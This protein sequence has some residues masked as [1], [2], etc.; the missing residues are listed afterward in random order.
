MRKTALECCRAPCIG[1]LRPCV[2]ACVGWLVILAGA[3]SAD[4]KPPHKTAVVNFYGEYL[5]EALRSCQLCHLSDDDISRAPAGTL[6]AEPQPWNA[7]GRALHELAE[8]QLAAGAVR[9]DGILDRI[10]ALAELD[11]DGDGVPNELE[12]VAGTVPGDATSRPDPERLATVQSALERFRLG[13]PQYAWKPFDPVVR[14][15]VSG[16]DA[17]D[18]LIAAEQRRQGLVPRPLAPKAMLLRRVYL[19]LIGLPPTREELAAF[20]ADDSPAAYAS[21]VD[22]LLSSPLYGERWGRHWMDVW[23]YSDWA[24]WGEQVRDSQPHIWRWR[25]WIIESLAADKPYDRMVQEMLAADELAPGDEDALRATGYLVR[26]FKLLSREQW[27]LEAVDHTSRA[28]LGVT[29]KCAQCHDHMYDPLTHEEY[30]QFRAIF[31]PYKVRID[32]VAGELDTKQAGLARVYD[33]DP[34]AK[35]QFYIRGDERTPDPD[36]QIDPAV[37]AFLGGG[38]L[39]CESIPLEYPQYY[40]ALRPSVLQDLRQQAQAAVDAA[41]KEFDAA[42][43]EFDAAR[44]AAAMPGD[45]VAVTA[46]DTAGVALQGESALAELPRG[47]WKLAEL[48]LEAAEAQQAALE[49]RIAADLAKHGKQE[50]RAASAD[51]SAD[52]SAGKQL[53]EPRDSEELGRRASQSERRAKWLAAEAAV[54]EARQRLSA[55]QRQLDPPR[56]ASASTDTASTDTGAGSL[57]AATV[58][59][60]KKEAEELQK[61]LEAAQTARDAAEKEAEGESTA[62]TAIGVTYATHSSGRRLALARWLIA[63]ENPLTARVAVNHIWARHFGRGLVATVDDF[64]LNGQRPA[65]PALL[66]WLAAELM[67]PSVYAPHDTAPSP[68]SMKHIH[69]LIVLSQAYQRDSGHDPHNAALD[70]DNRYLWRMQPRRLEAEAVR[71]SVLYVSGGLD[72]ARGG[73]EIDQHQ[74]LSV[75]RRSLY[76]RH[77]PEKQTQ[78]LQIFDMAAPTECYQRRDSVIPQQALAL[79]NS[80]LSIQQ[81]RRL[82]RQLTAGRNHPEFIT[83]AF[84][85]VLTRPPSESELDAC[86]AF[87]RERTA[88]TATAAELESAEPTPAELLDFAKPGSAAALRAR[89]NLVHVLMNHHEFVT[90]R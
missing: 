12:M 80:E 22:R 84:E 46:V 81:S 38:R 71:D 14:P 41:R 87:L 30:F 18:A 73:P 2:S 26:N 45:T 13:I 88:A 50:Q 77:A 74:A 31:E 28:F 34:A 35:T 82:A 27:M 5:P 7:F 53:P 47:A 20:I 61:K 17:I 68:W 57:D 43:K 67:E 42:R 11:S 59:K 75:P 49:A 29:F 64:G 58:E 36:K 24:G 16:S 66:D 69:R 25:D 19:D 33:D 54:L 37:P 63:R 51:A 62:Y 15:D 3:A 10:Q 40:P 85:Q 72:L 90:L 78:F 79:A 32:Q 4:A 44:T 9:P 60:L 65:L 86:L 55:V 89:E 23:R 8:Q 6:G 83:A 21:V 48:K 39:A 1:W 76:F 56:P 52:A 70:P